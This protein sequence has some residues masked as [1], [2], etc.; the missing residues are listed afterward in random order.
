M[1]VKSVISHFMLAVL[2]LA[3]CTRLGDSSLD[4]AND[5]RELVPVS[6]SLA[7]APTEDGMSATK[8]DYEP[9]TWGAGGAAAAI[10]T[11]LVLQFEWQDPSTPGTARLI[12]QQF[13]SDG[14]SGKVKLVV[15]KAKNT[16]FIIA[17]ASGRLALPLNLPLADFLERYNGNPLSAIDDLTGS[18]IW[19]SP[20]GTTANRYLRM[21][22]CVVLDDGVTAGTSL[23]AAYLKRNCAKVVVNVRNTSPSSNRVVIDGVQLCDINRNYH[24]VT[25]IPA[26]LAPLTLVDSYAGLDTERINDVEKAFLYNDNPD[27]SQQYIFYVPFN[28]RGSVAAVTSQTG[29]ND[30]APLGATFFRIYA[31]SGGNQVNYTYYMG[32]NLV[33]D[34]NLEPNKK[35]VY[36]ININGKGNAVTDSRIE[37]M[38]DVTFT[39]DANCYMLMPPASRDGQNPTR[40]YKIPVRR[41]AVFWNQSGTNMGVYGAADRPA[42]TLLEDTEWEASFVWNEIKD[43]DGKKVSDDVLLV[44]NAGVGHTSV[45][46]MGF[47][48][49]SAS[50]P[51]IRIRIGAGMK[52]NAVIAI[53]KTSGETL[54]DVLWSWHIWVTDYD[55]YIDR[56]P[57]A[58]TY[59]YTVPNGEIHRYADGAGKTL[60]ASGDYKTAFMMDRNVGATVANS[61]EQGNN[62]AIGCYYQWGRKDPFPTTGTVTTITADQAGTAPEGVGVKYNIRYSIHNPTMF[63]T[64]YSGNLFVWTSYENDPNGAI[65]GRANAAYIDPKADEHSESADYCE[66]GKSIYDPCPYGWRLPANDTWSDFTA[67]TREL[68]ASRAGGYYY[69]G[70]ISSGHGRIYFPSTGWRRFNTGVQEATNVFCCLRCSFSTYQFYTYN[71]GYNATGDQ[72]GGVPARCVRLSHKLPY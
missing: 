22:T 15:S 71:G 27:Q 63:I 5:G 11:L 34:F 60:W 24:F 50:N 12:H 69:P 18:G 19:Y 10:R 56:S 41:A 36:D 13:I 9:D 20:D 29:K 46:G 57:V 70:G 8:T 49:A 35:Y 3:G 61:G 59:I 55:P 48:P 44:D 16:V 32:A 65:I 42:Y 26:A 40:T 47:N 51:Y 2:L 37:D 66:T 21:N 54:H 38:S 33:T 17:N 25:E 1:S 23:G 28:E 68:L 72:S 6:L 64:P 53:R 43:K 52:G 58:D 67:S 30:Q 31:T 45:S 4:P 39:G 14:V 7:I 62:P